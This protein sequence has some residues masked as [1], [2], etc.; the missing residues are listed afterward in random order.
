MCSESHELISLMAHTL[1][2][3]GQIV[4]PVSTLRKKYSD[5]EAIKEIE[6]IYQGYVKAVTKMTGQ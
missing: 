6:R 2:S 1:G 3:I 5:E 4:K